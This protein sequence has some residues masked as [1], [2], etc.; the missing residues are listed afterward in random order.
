LHPLR[1]ILAGENLESLKRFEPLNRWQIESHDDAHRI[2]EVRKAQIDPNRAG[3]L[4]TTLPRVFHRAR[5]ADAHE[6]ASKRLGEMFSVGWT[7]PKPRSA[8]QCNPLNES[9]WNRVN[10]VEIHD[11]MRSR[12]AFDFAGIQHGIVPHKQES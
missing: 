2:W 4:A 11:S 6:I 5:K 1:K 7:K 10:L 3:D 9:K 12:E 8:I